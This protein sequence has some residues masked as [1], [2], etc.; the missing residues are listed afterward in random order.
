MPN[1]K[2]TNCGAVLK[3]PTAIAPGKKVKCP[4]CNEPFIVQADEEE[5][6]APEPEEDE[7]AA[8]KGLGGGGG[9]DDAP[10]P[11]KKGK[12][13]KG[14]DDEGAADGESE[15]GDDG[16]SKKKGK[17]KSKTGLII[18]IVAAVLLLC[19]CTPGCIVG[20]W[21][22]GALALFGIVEKDVKKADGAGKPAD[23][24]TKQED[25]KQKDPAGDKAK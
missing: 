16:A 15:D 19:C 6:P 12:P 20:A 4:K 11:K 1:I 5:K 8:F 9:D 24:K 23:A 21:Q 2:C 22:F 13:A 17:P 25:T 7:G 14:D 18:G 10:A 3:T